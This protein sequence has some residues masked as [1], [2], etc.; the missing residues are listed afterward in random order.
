M[1]P[2]QRQRAGHRS[3]RHSV[4]KAET[5]DK[6]VPTSRARRSYTRIT[7]EAGS[8]VGKRNCYTETTNKLKQK[9]KQQ[10]TISRKAYRNI[11]HGESK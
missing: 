3:H 2:I 5:N 9:R 10:N 11:A 4:L 1:L 8:R 6:S 7:E